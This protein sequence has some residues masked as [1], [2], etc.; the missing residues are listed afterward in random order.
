MKWM[1]RLVALAVVLVVPPGLLAQTAAPSGRAAAVPDLSGLWDN[2]H[3]AFGNPFADDPTRGFIGPGDIPFFGFTKQGPEMLPWAA[4]KYKERRTNLVRGPW[5]RGN[6]D[7]DPIHSCFPHGPTRMFTAPRPFELRQLPDV[8]LLLFE[9][10][11]WVRRVYLD[12]RGHPDGYPIT[13]MGHSVGRYDGDS[14]VADTIGMRAETWLDTLGHPHSEA[15]HV[16][17][18]F[19]RLDP[20]RL[21]IDFLFEDPET[22]ARPWTGKKIFQR[23]PPSFEILEVVQC[24]EWLEMGTKQ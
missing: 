11:H 5:D 7:F 6:D 20:A 4:A 23:A 14:L 1:S 13:W 8:V 9:S 18:R 12:G 2:S 21:Q 24:E 16:V 15:L 3:L 22:Y 17:E 10:D 19:R